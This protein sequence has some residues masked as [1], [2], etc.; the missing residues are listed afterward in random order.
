MPP[1]VSPQYHHQQQQQQILNGRRSKTPTSISP[2]TWQLCYVTERILA[3]ILPA[4]ESHLNQQRIDD[5]FSASYTDEN[6]NHRRGDKYETD[7]LHMLEQKH[8]KNFRLFDLESC[9]QTLSLE[10]LCEL[11]KHIE[12]WLNSGLNKIVVLQDRY[13]NCYWCWLSNTDKFVDFRESFQRVG[14]SVAAYL[15]YQKI[16]SSNLAPYSIKSNDHARNI[17]DLDEYSMQK[18]LEDNVGPI[19][20]PSYR[21][22]EM[23]CLLTWQ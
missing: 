16:C 1:S 10:K 17:Q 22:F 4:K 12:T 19:T 9:M 20:Q 21:R 14:T 7:L 18:F 2:N 5:L 13:V 23:R 8:G 11:C 6:G 3:A 15:Q